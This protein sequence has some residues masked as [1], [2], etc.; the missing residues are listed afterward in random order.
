MKIKCKRNDSSECL[1]PF[2]LK[3]FFFDLDHFLKTF[4]EYI[5]IF[6]L[7]VMFW[8]SAAK[9]VGILAS[10]PGIETTPPALEDK[11]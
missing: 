2:F 3:I 11:V 9:H 1:I 5:P 4:N 6:F 8:F 10:C 7:L